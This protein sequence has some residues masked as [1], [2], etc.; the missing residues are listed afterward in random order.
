MRSSGYSFLYEMVF[1]V[2]RGGF[3]IGETPIV[4]EDRVAG[5]SKISRSEIWRAAWHVLLAAVRPPKRPPKQAS[6]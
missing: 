2:H 4:F 5:A 3:R 6:E 1:L